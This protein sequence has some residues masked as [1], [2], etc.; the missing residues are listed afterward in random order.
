MRRWGKWFVWTAALGI[1]VCMAVVVFAGVQQ[2]RRDVTAAAVSTGEELSAVERFRMLREQLRAMEKAQLNVLAHNSDADPELAA[3]ARRQL[4][5][6]CQR[7]EQEL[8]LEGVLSMRGWA[9]P[10]VTVH[11][12][13]VN[14]LLRAE[15]VTRQE[16]AA[17]M[18][19][20]CRE[21]GVQSGNV[22]I[23]PMN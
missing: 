21:T 17:I 12:D 15:A 4:L 7:E 23:I 22:K 2:M 1:A 20:V 5:E 3:M 19:L 10:V 14:V 6:L 9:D 18:E 11:A 13:S 16:S 8:T